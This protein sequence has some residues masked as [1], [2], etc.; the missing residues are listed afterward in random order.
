MEELI[1]DDDDF[2]CSI[3]MGNEQAFG[4]LFN[5][6]KHKVYATALFFT[7]NETEAEE[8][9]QDVF[10]RI[11]KYRRKLP[12]VK[13]LSAWI[14]T[15]TRHR[16]L[17]VLKK[18]AI[19]YTKRQT[20]AYPADSTSLIDAESTVMQKDLHLLLQ[21]ALSCLTPQQRRIFELSRLEGLDRK[22]VAASL[23]LSPAT[24]SV[25]LTIAL[26]RVRTFLYDYNYELF[27]LFFFLATF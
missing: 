3:A 16:S 27:F 22:T 13:N 20:I 1:T 21:S 26:K 23:G 25:H 5:T 2:L 6:Y 17:T 18:I 11:W 10:S 19:E 12:Q 24:V 14:V 8:I 7:K 9:V 4:K 15:V